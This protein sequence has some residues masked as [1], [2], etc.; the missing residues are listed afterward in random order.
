MGKHL[1]AHLPANGRIHR[2]YAMENDSE[3]YWDEQGRGYSF[4]PERDVAG[5]PPR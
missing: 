3:H 1:L 5:I 4:D 2:Q